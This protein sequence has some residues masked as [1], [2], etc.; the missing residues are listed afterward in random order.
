[1]KEQ[2]DNAKMLKELGLSLK[3]F[4][5]AKGYSQEQLSE[6]AGLHPTYISQLE[7]GK[8]N[9]SMMILIAVAEQLD[10]TIVDLLRGSAINESE[11]L[12]LELKEI[13]STS[14]TTQKQAVTTILEGIVKAYRK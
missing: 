2:K 1:M 14:D 5:K 6:L 3:E 4:R 13:L 12:L 9:P 10:I 11:A 8:A 7:T